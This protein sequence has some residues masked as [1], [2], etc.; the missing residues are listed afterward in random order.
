MIDVIK[1]VQTT[2][3]GT[4]CPPQ[5]RSNAAFNLMVFNASE[6]TEE[7]SPAD[8][9][10]SYW[11]L[12]QDLDRDENPDEYIVYSVNVHEP[13][14]GADGV[15]LIYRSY[16]TIRYFCKDAWIGDADKYAPI[17]NR[18][19]QIRQV[20]KAADFDITSGWQDIGDVDGISYE[21]FVLTAVYTEV[22]FGEDD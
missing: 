14:A 18:M 15:G 2:L 13:G 10:R 19:N 3:D 4:L 12:R 22:D 11:L 7:D 17:Q 16:V 20:L 21:T 5:Y 9:L 1:L 6:L 8:P